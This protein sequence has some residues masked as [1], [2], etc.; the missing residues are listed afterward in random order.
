MIVVDGVSK[1]YEPNRRA[2]EPVVALDN[3]SLRI[4]QANF[5]T[6][7]GPSGCGKSTLLRLIAGMEEPSDGLITINGE[8]VT[9]ADP[10]R[11][12]VWQEF[13]LMEW[14]TVSD[15]VA[16]GLEVKGMGRRERRERV[17]EMLRLVRLERFADHYP[18]QLSGGMRQRVAIARALAVDPDIL[19][20][21]EPFG[22]LDAQTRQLMQEE[23]LRIW[24]EWRKT[25]VFVTHSLDE[26]LLLSD[27]VALFTSRPG[28]IKSVVPVPMDRPRTPSVRTEPAYRDLY[29]RLSESLRTEVQRATE[30][31]FTHA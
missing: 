3:V 31:E 25:V 24:E 7:I 2:D 4:E 1:I 22:A 16:F 13:A 27:Q 8:R 5:Y 11:I 17:R 15:N 23:L 12:V 26:A 10:R 30:E 29:E 19:L 6:F 20:M 9:G 28:Q 21:D 18:S 14:R